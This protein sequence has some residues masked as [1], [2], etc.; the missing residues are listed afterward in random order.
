MWVGIVA[1]NKGSLIIMAHNL[2][3]QKADALLKEWRGQ[4]LPVYTFKHQTEHLATEA[5]TC[6]SCISV[7]KRIIARKGHILPLPGG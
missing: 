1:Y 6:S 4:G 7:V 3:Q 5:K 2:T